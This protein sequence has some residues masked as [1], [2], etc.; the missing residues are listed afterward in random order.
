MIYN[1]PTTRRDM[2]HRHN[3]T[4]GSVGVM[5]SHLKYIVK[6]STISPAA[7]LLAR[8]VEQALDKLE[9]EL[10]S[11][12]LEDGLQVSID[13]WTPESQERYHELLMKVGRHG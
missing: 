9:L 13:H 4:L 1:N 8:D 5:R 3:A 10:R 6:C 11:C 2:T 12:R 7:D